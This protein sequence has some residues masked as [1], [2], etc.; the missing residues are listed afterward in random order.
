MNNTRRWSDNQ[1]AFWPFTYSRDKH[2]TFGAVI[3]SG[4]E[5][6]PDCHL[7]FRA[8]GHTLIIE[9]PQLIQRDRKWVDTSKYAWAGSSG[10][11]WDENSNEF[12]FSLSDGFLQVFYGPQTGD[13]S[14]TKVWCKFLPLAQWRFIRFSLYGLSGEHF[15]TQ[16]EV[17]RKRGE[18]DAQMKM[19]AQCPS[20][21]FEFEDFDG[22][23]ITVKTHIEER[24]WLFGEGWFKWLSIFRRPKVSRCLDLSFSKEVGPRKGSW[25]GGTLGHAIE[26]L[27]NELHEAAFYRYC[28]RYQLRFISPIP[29]E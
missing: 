11:Y 22:E 23:R 19:E 24:E 15:W 13:S 14:T 2:W 29:S 6:S 17:A 27:P 18:F 16:R 26:M 8:F 20:A 10:G 1:A 7:R 9:M 12:G 25:K 3:D 28:A 4:D 21:S 5:Y